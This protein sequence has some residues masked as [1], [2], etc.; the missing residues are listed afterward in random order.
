VTHEPQSVRIAAVIL[1][2]GE[3]RRFGSPK[4]L[5]VHEGQPLVRRAAIAALDAGL[6]PV[7]VV[8]GANAAPIAPALAGL[9]VTIVVNDEWRTG[10][11]SS[12]RAGIE[13]ALGA[14][15]DGAL[16]MLADQPLVDAAS[17]SKIIAKFDDAHR[18]VAAQY[19]GV[20]GAPALLGIEHLGR[21]ADL[22]GDTGAGKWLRA[23]GERVT[24]VPMPEAALDVDTIGD[25][26]SLHAGKSVR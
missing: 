2:A 3:S 17:L 10:Q 20:I 22:S 6:Q 1:A 21:L 18:I 5:L 11:A 25:F 4:Q 23:H 15:I 14:R 13:A 8:L 9:N 7:I 26:D 16:V 12:L 19:G 24:S